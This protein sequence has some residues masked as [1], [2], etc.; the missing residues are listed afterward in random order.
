VSVSLIFGFEL[1]SLKGS[2]ILYEDSLLDSKSGSSASALSAVID[3]GTTCLILPSRV[4][5]KQIYTGWCDVLD[6]IFKHFLDI[7]SSFLSTY[8]SLS[9]SSLSPPSLFILFT[10]SKIEVEIPAALYTLPEISPTLDRH[11]EERLQ[12]KRQTS[13]TSFSAVESLCVLSLPDYPSLF[14]LGDVFLQAAGI[15]HNL[16]DIDKPTLTLI[17]RGWRKD[18]LSEGDETQSIPPRL[19]PRE[20]AQKHSTLFLQKQMMTEF[21]WQ[22]Q[23]LPRLTPTDTPLSL[24]SFLSSALSLPD[25][26]PL[27]CV[28]GIQYVTEI[29]LGIPAQK[30][31]PVIIDTGSGS[32]ILL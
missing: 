19:Q 9:R 20:G 24:L 23:Q 8:T 32:L 27:Q 29:A 26:V 7:F 2:H 18:E 6:W 14:V 22:T 12:S 10:H 30:G 5:T 28:Q 1:L 3:S 15:V 25:I 31:I 4:G 13:S 21:Q 11:T 16:S 17:P